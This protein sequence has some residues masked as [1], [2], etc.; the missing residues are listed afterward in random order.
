VAVA[1]LVPP[2]PFPTKHVATR[3][4][5]SAATV[6]KSA[7]FHINCCICSLL[8]RFNCMCSLLGRFFNCIG[9]IPLRQKDRYEHVAATSARDSGVEPI[10]SSSHRCVRIFNYQQ[11]LFI[12]S[13]FPIM[14]GN[15]AIGKQWKEKGKHTLVDRRKRRQKC[16]TKAPCV[17]H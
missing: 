6:A 1:Q 9:P 10:L 4:R 12:L 15:T 3:W 13:S 7:A 16:S 14:I 5:G 11:I 8:G 17:V 2:F